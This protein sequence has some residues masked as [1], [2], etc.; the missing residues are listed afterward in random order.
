MKRS[1]FVLRPALFLV[2]LLGIIFGGLGAWRT[3]A[4][5]RMCMSTHASSCADFA[6][7]DSIVAKFVLLGVGSAP[8]AENRVRVAATVEPC[9]QTA[10][11]E[12][13]LSNNNSDRVW[14]SRP[15]NRCIVAGCAPDQCLQITTNC[16]KPNDKQ[17][18]CKQAVMTREKYA[19][20]Q[21][22]MA[23]AIIGLGLSVFCIVLPSA[24]T[25]LKQVDDE[26]YSNAGYLNPITAQ[27]NSTPRGALLS[28]TD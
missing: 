27:G 20:Y 19:D 14:L 23:I 1:L 11:N 7:A 5:P 8:K 22:F 13:M 4:A 26:N 6:Q 3:K 10:T 2:G 28:N 25:N 17:F 24:P 18:T 12:Y 16:A 9:L 15:S 21:V